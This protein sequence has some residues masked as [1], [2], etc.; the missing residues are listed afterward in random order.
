MK[1]QIH[2]KADGRFN[3]RLPSRLVFSRMTA[4]WLAK[5]L[6]EKAEGKSPLTADDLY[7]LFKLLLRF[8]KDYPGFR[9]VEVD[10]KNG[11]RVKITL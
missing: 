9:L 7:R 2:T 11:D 1:I 8:K 5:A 10:A 3:I 6:D 4:S